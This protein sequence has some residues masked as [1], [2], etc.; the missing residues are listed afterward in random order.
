MFEEVLARLGLREV[1]SGACDSAWVDRPGGAE[2]VSRNPATGEPIGG[3]VAAST[4]DY[5]RVVGRASEAFLS[6]RMVPPPRRGEVVR[7]IGLALRE[8][9]RDLGTLVTL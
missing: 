1:N 2:I 7:Q 5:A 4:D 9:R 8:R 3:V 6:W